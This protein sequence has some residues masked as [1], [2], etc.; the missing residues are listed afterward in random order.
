MFVFIV[1]G[2]YLAN[3]PSVHWY[4]TKRNRWRSLAT[5]EKHT[6]VGRKP[7]NLEASQR[8]K[9]DFS[10]PE[11]HPVCFR[12]ISS[13]NASLRVCVFLSLFKNLGTLLKGVLH[14][15]TD[16]RTCFLA[17]T[18]ETSVINLLTPNVNYSGRTAPLTSKVA[19][20]IFIQ[21]I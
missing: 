10:S 14:S 11:W 16:G 19:F 15:F 8:N 7:S 17:D 2:K 12:K 5:K 6:Y 13:I 21:Q 9:E 3:Q 1:N 18:S 20:Y 4:T